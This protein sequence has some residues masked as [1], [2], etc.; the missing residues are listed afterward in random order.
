V[1]TAAVVAAAV[2]AVKDTL[3]GVDVDEAELARQIIT[4]LAAP[5][6]G[7]RELEPDYQGMTVDQLEAE[8]APAEAPADAPDLDKSAPSPQDDTPGHDGPTPA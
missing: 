3:S 1:D 4:Q 8:T 5:P 2:A 7:S 6:A